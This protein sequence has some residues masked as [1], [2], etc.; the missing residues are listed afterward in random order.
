MYEFSIYALKYVC[1]YTEVDPLY[2]RI[3]YHVVMN[4]G[5][6]YTERLIGL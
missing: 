5:S 6:V 4:K 2:R 3:C 1:K